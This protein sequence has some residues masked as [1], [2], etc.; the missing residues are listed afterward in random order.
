MSPRHTNG[1][2]RDWICTLA[3]PHLD[4]AGRR[5]GVHGLGG[6][7]TT[8]PVTVGTRSGAANRPAQ[9]ANC[10]LHDVTVMPYGPADR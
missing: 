6:R 4:G 5:V 10:R 7:G 9:K 1:L 2:G 3:D 8:G